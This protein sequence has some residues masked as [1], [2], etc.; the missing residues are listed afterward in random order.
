MEATKK[1]SHQ[2]SGSIAK[3]VSRAGR[4]ETVVSANAQDIQ[5]T[6]FISYAH[7][8]DALRASVKA[9]AVWLSDRGCSVLTDHPYVHRPPERGWQ[10]WMHDCLRKADVVLVVCTPK[11]KARYEKNEEPGTGF[12]ATY[13]GA[14]VT[15]HI[16]DA[17]MRNTKFFPV[18]SIRKPC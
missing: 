3:D 6:V 11:L 8:S 9:L 14:V 17:A 2:L 1:T 13:E 16:Y 4:G 18:G 5:P 10:T 7:E 12:G 15:Q